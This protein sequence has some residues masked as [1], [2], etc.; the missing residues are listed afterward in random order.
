MSINKDSNKNSVKDM[1]P[2]GL[3]V[4]YMVYY[5]QITLGNRRLQIQILVYQNVI[6]DSAMECWHTDTLIRARGMQQ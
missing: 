1:E 6:G 3:V 5:R 2:D 4:F